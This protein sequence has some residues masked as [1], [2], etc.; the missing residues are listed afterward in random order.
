VTEL[1]PTDIIH[2]QIVRISNTGNG[3]L[4]YGDGEIPIGP[5]K[6]TAVGQEVDAVV[7]DQNLALCLAESA[8]SENYDNTVRAI[9]QDLTG[10]PPAD[11]PGLGDIIKIELQG[12]NSSRHGPAEY[13]GIPVRVRNIPEDASMGDII[14]VKVYRIEQS[15]LIATGHTD[16]R[17]RSQLPDVGSKFSAIV[18][19]RTHSGNGLVE[20][21]TDEDINIGPIQE[22]VVGEP[23]SAV[24]LEDG[25]AYCLDDNSV[26]DGYDE[27]MSIHVDDAPGLLLTEL[28]ERRRNKTQN[29]R[30]KLGRI[31][32]GNTSRSSAFRNQVVEAYDGTCAVCGQR[33][34]DA[35]S[36]DYFEIEAAHIY[37]VSGVE[38]DDATEG[39]PDTIKNGFA[40]CRT[41]HWAFDNGWFTISDDYTINIEG[42]PSQP[43]YEA[44]EQYDGTRLKLP[45][46][47]SLWPAQ[48]YLQAHRERV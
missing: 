32:R 14:P 25:W 2:G 15:R 42:D 31:R 27:A 34:T 5:I 38:V 1:L 10:N 11:C 37:P 19:R 35:N 18:S 29:T 44:L 20:S 23:V 30:E 26:S 17:L 36:G 6:E 47:K 21:F 28:S 12:I 9:M 33:I 24:F 3:I 7:Y 46:D 43:G 8:R 41:H 40:L 48:Y 22:G 13:K 4:D 16:I 39:G 45:E